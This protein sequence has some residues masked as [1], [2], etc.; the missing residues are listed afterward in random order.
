MSSTQQQP[1]PTINSCSMN[2]IQNLDEIMQRLKLSIDINDEI[3]ARLS[4]NDFYILKLIFK[5][6]FDS[7]SINHKTTTLNIN[8]KTNF[9]NNDEQSN[10]NL[11][12]HYWLKRYISA[13]FFV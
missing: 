6:L 11:I 12:K 10:F 13:V 9:F 2:G 4:Y 3:V 7:N 1:K 5:K 8:K